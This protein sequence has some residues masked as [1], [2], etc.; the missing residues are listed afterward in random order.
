M[1]SVNLIKFLDRY[2]GSLICLVLSVFSF[3]PKKV[4]CKRILLIQ[5]WGLGETVLSLPAIKELRQRYKNSI[6]DIVTTG[7]VKDVFYNNKSISSIKVVNLNPFSIKWFILKNFRKYDIAID[8]EEYLNIS[9][10]IAFYAGNER[11]GYSHGIRSRLYTKK[12]LYN[13][14][15]HVSQAFMD[16]LKP[17]GIDKKAKNLERL[18]YSEKDKEKIDSLLEDNNISKKDFIVGLGI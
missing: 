13:D 15:Q 5:L 12:I 1:T 16:L 3:K 9:A 18:N 11:I 6:I 2:L 14:G 4:S 17:L 8:M 7:R 10:I